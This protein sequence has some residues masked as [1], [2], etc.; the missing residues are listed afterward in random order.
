MSK[1]QYLKIRF[2]LLILI[3]ALFILSGCGYIIQKK[4]NLPF[5]GLSIGKI[6]NKT[7]EPKLED[8]FRRSMS[9][10]LYEYGFDLNPN[11][12]YILEG[13]IISFNLEPLVEKDL[14]ATQY[15]IAVKANFRIKN[16]TKNEALPLM[17][18]MPFVT[19]FRSAESLD[20]VLAQK[21]LATKK[22]I[23]DMSQEIVRLIVY[24]GLSDK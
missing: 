15:K 14:T 8:I 5:E 10:I 18:K 9:E 19:Y 12:K 16:S 1:I 17:I 23:R 6:E 21:E 20:I 11:S 4:A 22:A 3:S 24:K 7:V 13:E 2:L